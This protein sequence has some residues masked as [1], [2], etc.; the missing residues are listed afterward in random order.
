MEVLAGAAPHSAA[1][2]A[3]RLLP[4]AA[5]VAAADPSHVAPPTRQGPVPAY[6]T[7]PGASAFAPQPA[8]ISPSE[9]DLDLPEAERKLLGTIDAQVVDVT[10]LSSQYA[11]AVDMFSLAAQTRPPRVAC[12]VAIDGAKTATTLIAERPSL[13]PTFGDKAA[14]IGPVPLS[15]GATQLHLAVFDRYTVRDVVLLGH[16]SLHVE[17]LPRG[18]PIYVWLPLMRPVL[19]GGKGGDGEAAEGSKGPSGSV[20]K[21][22]TLKGVDTW[23]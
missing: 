19:K 13:R 6:G 4:P 12:H 21:H 15:D 18:D 22:V 9:L 23:R 10:G 11:G 8:F 7:D 17:N 5:A 16:V 14:K 2:A 1:W 3:A 20:D